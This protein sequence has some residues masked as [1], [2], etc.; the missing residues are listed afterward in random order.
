MSRRVV[1]AR[2]GRGRIAMAAR[3]HVGGVG[4]AFGAAVRVWALGGRAMLRSS[5][6]RDDF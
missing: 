3:G 2:E 6:L 4:R 1:T 5:D